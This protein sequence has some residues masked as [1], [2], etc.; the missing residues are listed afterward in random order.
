MLKITIHTEAKVT[1]FVIE[2]KL[3]GPWVEELEKC[4]KSALAADPSRTMLVNLAAVTFI[5]S[6]GRA[7]LSRMRR[8]GARLLSTGVLI[9]A[10]VAEIEAEEGPKQQNAAMPTKTEKEPPPLAKRPAGA[11]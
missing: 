10:I 11:Q 1:S 7:L 5:D 4:W 6:A 2:G 9:N 8:Q 3:V